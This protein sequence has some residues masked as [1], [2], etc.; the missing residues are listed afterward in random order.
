MRL[1]QVELS[2]ELLEGTS[3]IVY[4]TLAQAKA[5]AI[6]FLRGEMA[7]NIGN[8]D[9]YENGRDPDDLSATI[10]LIATTPINARSLCDIINSNGGSYVS[11]STEI[12]KI[13]LPSR[14]KRPVITRLQE[15][16]KS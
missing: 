3:T 13:T 7:V 15:A 5:S 10:S 12:L 8:I 16:A 14:A 4:A 11:E 1:Y 6:S 2:F 9:K